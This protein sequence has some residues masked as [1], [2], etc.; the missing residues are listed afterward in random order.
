MQDHQFFPGHRVH[1]TQSVGHSTRTWFQWLTMT[2]LLH[3]C[4]SPTS[5]KFYRSV[6]LILPGITHSGNHN[7][8]I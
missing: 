4:A 3:F 7:I 1:S 8:G 6:N 2:R 5:L